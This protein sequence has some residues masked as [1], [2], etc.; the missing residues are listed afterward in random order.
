MWKPSTKEIMQ[1]TCFSHLELV[2]MFQPV[3]LLVHY[4]QAAASAE[5]IRELTVGY[6]SIS[7]ACIFCWTPTERTC[8]GLCKCSPLRKAPAGAEEGHL[9]SSSPVLQDGSGE[10]SWNGKKSKHISPGTASE[11]RTQ[12]Q[13]RSAAS[14]EP[15]GSRRV[16]RSESRNTATAWRWWKRADFFFFNIPERYMQDFT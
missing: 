11:S 12:Q 4:L 14:R 7:E 16:L 15:G 8:L 9:L 10:L 13:R 1:T 5:H 3:P 2:F 6:L